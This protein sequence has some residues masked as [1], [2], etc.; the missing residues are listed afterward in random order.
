M[1]EDRIAKSET[2]YEVELVLTCEMLGT[3]PKNKEIY[4]DYI[5]SKA[6][7]SDEE[8][9]EELESVPESKDEESGWTGF[10]TDDEG[11]PF[12][13]DYVIKGFFKDACGMLRRAPGTRSKALTAHKKVIDGLVF[14]T[15]RQIHLLLPEGAELGVLERPLRAT[16]AKGDRVALARSDTAPA[17]TVIRFTVTVV[18]NQVPE[19]LLHEW[20]TYGQ[21]RGLGQ[22]RNAGYGTF[23]YT[24]TKT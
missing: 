21:R 6:E 7:L 9:D 19:A 17:G 20:F 24:L 22:W 11:R 18:G 3:V 8:L 15:P 16:T 12:I 4:G 14:A 2:I 1:A 5:A 13:Y 10:H 23:D